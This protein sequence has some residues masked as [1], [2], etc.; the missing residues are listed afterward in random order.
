[1]LAIAPV[2]AMRDWALAKV[3]LLRELRGERA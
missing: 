3:W 2:T 1:V